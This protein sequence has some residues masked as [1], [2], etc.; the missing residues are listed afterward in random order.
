METRDDGEP[1][2]PV[3]TAIHIAPA[4]RLPMRRVETIRAEAGKGLVGDRYHGTRHRHVTVQSQAALDEAAAELGAPVDPA[5][6]RRNVTISE[7]DVPEAPGAR[8]RIGDVELEVVR[9]AA[10]CKLLDDTIG[11]GANAAAE[12]TGRFGPPR[13]QLGLDL[14]RRPRRG[15]VPGSAG[16]RRLNRRRGQ[17]PAR[18]ASTPA[19]ARQRAVAPT[20]AGARSSRA[21]ARIDP[22]DPIDRID[23]L[24]PIDRMDPLEAIERIDPAEPTEPNDATDVA[25]P[26]DRT[27]PADTADRADPTEPHDSTDH[28][29]RL[30]STERSIRRT[31]APARIAATVVAGRGPPAPPA[32]D[33]RSGSFRR[34]RWSDPPT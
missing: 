8:I 2:R 21:V 4:S 34:A 22:L 30:D 29:E 17:R 24:D 31:V 18:A 3:V 9:R 28:R 16:A 33:P 27:E 13:A 23:P 14:G 5:G 12:A 26:K 19:T 20:A 10:P 1:L 15:R 32:A 7:G 11:P 6:T 25:E